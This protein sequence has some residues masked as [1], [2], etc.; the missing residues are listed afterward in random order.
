MEWEGSG[1]FVTLLVGEERALLVDTGFGV[2][3]LADQVGGMTDRPLTVVNTHGH[4]DHIGGNY[5]FPSVLLHP[6]D[7]PSAREAMLESIKAKVE[8]VLSPDPKGYDGEAYHR[9]HLENLCPLEDGAVFDLGGMTARAVLLGTH[10]PGSMGFYIPER[11]LLLTGDCLAPMMY[12][13]FPESGPLSGL[14]QAIDRLEALPFDRMLAS[15][16]GR[17]LPRRELLLYRECAAHYAPPPKGRP[18]RD[19]FFPQYTGRMY[20][21]AWSE[22]PSQYAIL[23]GK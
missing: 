15:H 11:S 8:Q 6:D 23:I 2:C 7:L 9:Y 12:M 20:S 18:H 1:V 16:C 4:N 5:Q 10:S 17:L 22:D 19:I 13:F 21:H 14:I 3:D